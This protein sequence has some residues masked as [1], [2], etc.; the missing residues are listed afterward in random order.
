MRI[1]FG[2]LM[3]SVA[4]AAS[5]QTLMV[6]NK[7]EHTISFIDLA[8][9]KEVA[10]RETGRAPHEMAVSPDGRT[11]V[12]VSY[13]EKGFNGTTLHLFDVGGARAIGTI[14][15]P[16]H[17]G[18]H[19]LKWLPGNKVIVTSEVTKN[20]ALV[21]VAKRKLVA[22]IPTGQ[23]VSHMVAVG[24]GARTAYVANIGSGSFSA[25]DLKTNRKTDDVA[26]GKGAEAIAVSP[27][28]RELWVGANGDKKVVL[29]DIATLKKRA[30][31]P[32][33]GVPIRVEFTPNGRHAVISL[34]DANKVLVVDA[35]SRKTLRAID[36]GAMKLEGPV[37]MLFAPDGK[38]LWV[39]ATGSEAVAEIDPRSW[40][41]VR[42]LKA[43]KSA[44][45]LA[46]S[47]A[48]TRPR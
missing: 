8:T 34:P 18:L 6:G 30:E 5:G 35:R 25:I 13:R 33:P 21:D 47:R 37:T 16:G 31:F 22:S 40:T 26:I 15:L 3:A 27:D 12:A 23:D 2:L 7:V 41:V 48:I 42:T 10:R 9:G 46:F 14:P 17:E 38:R 20:V 4:G 45:G 28:G 32:T 43:G 44:D 24:P 19:G 29:F 36:L 39:A 1:I 11:A